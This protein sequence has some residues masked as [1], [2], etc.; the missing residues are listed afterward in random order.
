MMGHTTEA[1][2]LSGAIT[3]AA[4]FASEGKAFNEERPLFLVERLLGGFASRD[5]RGRVLAE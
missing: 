4:F 2:V 5:L 1:A 3:M